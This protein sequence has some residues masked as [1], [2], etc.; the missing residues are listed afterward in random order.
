MIKPSP[1]HGYNVSGGLFWT[2]SQ[3][4]GRQLADIHARSLSI[5][6]GTFTK[7]KDLKVLIVTCDNF[8]LDVQAIHCPH[9]NI[10]WYLVSII[11]YVNANNANNS[12]N[13]KLSKTFYNIG[14][15]NSHLDYTADQNESSSAVHIQCTPFHTY[16]GWMGQGTASDLLWD[17]APNLGWA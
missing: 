15:W 1:S 5:F 17:H 12:D 9:T 8:C 3:Q 4:E 10:K 2:S 7:A 6:I 14:H 13:Y 11:K 16:S